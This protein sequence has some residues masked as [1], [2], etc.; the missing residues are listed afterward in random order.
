[1]VKFHEVDEVFKH[2]DVMLKVV[3]NK[4]K[5]CNIGK[6]NCHFYKGP[7][8]KCATICLPR[9]RKDNKEV[10]YLKQ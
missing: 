7:G 6:Q 1:M 3:E 9:E 5:S 8:K 10:V 4:M 2:N